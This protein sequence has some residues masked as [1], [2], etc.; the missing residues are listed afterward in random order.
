[1]DKLSAILLGK[2]NQLFNK[3]LNMNVDMV[4]VRANQETRREKRIGKERETERDKERE[5]QTE[6]ERMRAR[7]KK[8]IKLI[9]FVSQLFFKERIYNPE[10]LAWLS[11]IINVCP[12]VFLHD[13]IVSKRMDK[14][15]R[16]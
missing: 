8:K 7:K 2:K 9:R 14:I 3:A 4:H 5:R 11:Y 1:M 6:I 12:S 13:N 15:H 10:Y 16:W